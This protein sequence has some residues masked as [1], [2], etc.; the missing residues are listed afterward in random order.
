M[1][2]IQNQNNNLIKVAGDIKMKLTTEKLK[3][4]IL[5]ELNEM[6]IP[7]KESMSDKELLEQAIMM[8]D[9]IMKTENFQTNPE[10]HGKLAPIYQ[11][12]QKLMYSYEVDPSTGAEDPNKLDIY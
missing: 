3:K 10:L 12:L 4:L 7:P 9:G 11:M 2:I 5:E 8:L 6:A 1:R